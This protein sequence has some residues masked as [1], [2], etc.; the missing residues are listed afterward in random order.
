M[1]ELQQQQLAAIRER[2]AKMP[3]GDYT[4]REQHDDWG[5][6]RRPDGW[7]F[8]DVCVSVDYGH[9]DV[10]KTAPDFVDAKREFVSHAVAD[11]DTLL[12]MLADAELRRS[13]TVAMCD[14]LRQDVQA[15]EEEAATAA[16]TRQAEIVAWLKQCADDQED[17]GDDIAIRMA[18]VSIERGEFR[19]KGGGDG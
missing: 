2:R 5:L 1:N 14:L 19:E 10:G 17:R 7:P 8:A 9:E 11:I 15:A 18:A 13:E 3:D 12:A 16:D 6:V 4:K